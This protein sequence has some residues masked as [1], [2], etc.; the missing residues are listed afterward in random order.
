MIEKDNL[1][2][3]VMKEILSSKDRNK[4]GKKISPYGLTLVKVEY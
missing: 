4:A 1:S 2:P 3:E